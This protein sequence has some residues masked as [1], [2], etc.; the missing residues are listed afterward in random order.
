MK[1]LI[2]LCAMAL[3]GGTIQ[4]QIIKNVPIKRAPVGAYDA[5]ARSAA[6]KAQ[7]SIEAVRDRYWPELAKTNDSVYVALYKARAAFRKADSLAQLGGGGVTPVGFLKKDILHDMIAEI[8]GDAVANDYVM[9]LNYNQNWRPYQTLIFG[10]TD[11]TNAYFKYENGIIKVN[12]NSIPAGTY[13]LK[14]TVSDS[15]YVDTA[16]MAITVYAPAVCYYIDPTSTGTGVGTKAN[17]YKT[18]TFSL[19]NDRKYFFKRGTTTTSTAPKGVNSGNLFGAYGAGNRPIIRNTAASTFMFQVYAK[20]NVTIRDLEIEDAGSL[21]TSCV[22]VQPS[23]TNFNLINCKLHGNVNTFQGMR[24]FGLIG[25]SIRDNEF[26]NFRDDNV[27]IG[28]LEGTSSADWFDIVGNYSH[29]P[30]LGVVTLGTGANGDCMQI[31]ADSRHRRLY[32]AYNNFDHSATDYK[33][34]LVLGCEIEATDITDVEMI[35]EYNLFISKEVQT[36]PQN[37]LSICGIRGAHVRYNEMWYGHRNI[38]DF[39]TDANQN[40]KIYGN[41]MVGGKTAAIQ[42]NGVNSDN[43][44]VY[45][46]TM[47]NTG[48]ST[49]DATHGSILMNASQTGV[50]FKNNIFYNTV[51]STNVFVNEPTITE[52]YNIFYPNYNGL[53][54]IGGNSS[55]ANPLF[56]K[57]AHS[58]YEIGTNSPA[59]HSGQAL[60]GFTTG[61]RDIFNVPWYSTPSRGYKER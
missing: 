21:S 44:L 57:G 36:L 24:I 11:L 31:S 23:S 46:N 60:T 45:N 35:C 42:F 61:L 33:H 25:G 48:N 52:D 47:V 1:T 49:I 13:S 38:F 50:V 5:T 14:F 19:A 28:G 56:V 10:V 27:F 43:V 9:E 59:Y 22:Y 29:H 8:P 37:N 4:A 15:V 20:T 2:L 54:S 39:E 18:M 51:S 7:D 17:P 34:C 55:V 58:A 30:N 16:T 32:L 26:Y 6:Q 53:S 3:M 40:V 41:L 12:T